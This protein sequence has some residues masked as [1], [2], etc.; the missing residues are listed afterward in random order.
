MALDR[1]GTTIVAEAVYVVAGKV[2]RVSGDEVLLALGTR[3]QEVVRVQASDVVRVDDTTTG[4]PGGGVSEAEAT[5]IAA[6]AISTHVAASDPHAQYQQES[7]K[8]AADGYAALN[9][10]SVVPDAQLPA[11][12]TS[13][14]GIVR[15]ATSGSA[16]S[17]RAVE[18]T[19]ARL[20]DSRAPTA[21]SHP[22][23]DLNAEVDNCLVGAPSGEEGFS[24][25]RLYAPFVLD[26][27]DGLQILPGSL[28]PAMLADLAGLSVFGRSANT[29]GVGGEITAGTDGHVLRRSGTSLAFGALAAGAFGDNTIG[30]P[31]LS[32]AATG[33]SVIARTAGSA[34]AWAEV[35]ATS[36]SDQ[37]LRESGGSIGWGTIATGG[38]ANAAVTNAKLANMAAST[39]KARVTGSTGAPED[40]TVAQILAILKC[41]YQ[42]ASEAGD[43]VRDAGASSTSEA[44]VSSLVIPGNTIGANGKAVLEILGHVLQ[45]RGSANTATLR[46]KFGSTTVYAKATSIANAAQPKPFVLRVH[47]ANLASTSKQRVHIELIWSFAL[48]PTAGNGDWGEFGGRGF[49]LVGDATEDTTGDRAVAVTVQWDNSSASSYWR[50]HSAKVTV[51]P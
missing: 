4:G 43:P 50:V 26:A 32:N 37:V 19:D 48:S 1:L 11:A 10:S 47:V 2:R 44:T 40:A 16:T 24:A 36:S 25:L 14:A 34:G 5:A 42:V 23:T 7:E 12:S 3:G 20:S 35:S 15:L 27:V 18:A 30:L 39:I 17:G 29:A 38:I 46:V 22:L 21:H 28:T 31:R 51:E 33:R 8:G 6:A 13:A 45:N 9:S 49:C 41:P